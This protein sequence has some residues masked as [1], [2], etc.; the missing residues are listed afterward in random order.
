[1]KLKQS[2]EVHKVVFECA[3]IDWKKQSQ[4]KDD[5]FMWF[6]N[7]NVIGYVRARRVGKT[8]GRI[9]NRLR[10]TVS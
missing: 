3:Q 8:C 10:L 6:L 1:M 2:E 4:A 5:A 7:H 9:P